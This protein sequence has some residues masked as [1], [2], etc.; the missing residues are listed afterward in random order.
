MKSKS[1]LL[2]AAILLVAIFCVLVAKIRIDERYDLAKREMLMR[3]VG[4]EILLRS[5]DSTS[6]V[7]P[8]TKAGEK[9]RI[10][11]EKPFT[12]DHDTLVDTVRKLLS[13]DRESPDYMVKVMDCHGDAI[14]FGYAIGE[15]IKDD[16]VGCSGRTQPKGCYVVSIEFKDAPLGVK[17]YAAAASVFALALLCPFIVLGFRKKRK[18]QPN[19]IQMIAI[20]SIL[21]DQNKRQLVVSNKTINLTA[22]E[23]RILSIFAQYP[24]Q[25]VDRAR[26]QKEIWE[27]DG[28]IVG[29]SLDMFISKLRKKLESDPSVQLVN[30][31]G[32]GY[33]L[34]IGSLE[35]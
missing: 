21:F 1:L 25:V 10:S 9:Y 5:G 16:V 13:T 35:N 27:D 4:H 17:K 2:F 12:F 14:V 15:T 11:F 33:K 19:S 23:N 20:G 30:I 3:K 18:V 34:Q 31:H 7:L 6:R 8:V 29:R 32:K 24:N 22:K 26:L 28:V